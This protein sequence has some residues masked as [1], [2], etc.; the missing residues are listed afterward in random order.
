MTGDAVLEIAHPF[1]TMDHCHGFAGMFVTA[2]TGVFFKVLGG[3]ASRTGN[4]VARVQFEKFRMVESR[5]FHLS[6]A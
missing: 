2:V 3:M 4:I 5:S 6:C 1:T